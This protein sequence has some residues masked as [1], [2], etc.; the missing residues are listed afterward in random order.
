MASA[1]FYKSMNSTHK[2]SF[3]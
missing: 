2:M 3:R 1:H